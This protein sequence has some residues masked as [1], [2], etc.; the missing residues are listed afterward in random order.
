M[1]QPWLRWPPCWLRRLDHC[2]LASDRHQNYGWPVIRCCFQSDL[3]N[4]GKK[5]PRP[6]QDRCGRSA[7]HSHLRR[8]YLHLAI[9]PGTDLALSPS[10][11][12]ALFLLARRN[13]RF[14]SSSR[15]H[16]WLS[17]FAAVLKEWNATHSVAAHLVC[18]SAGQAAGGWPSS[19]EARGPALSPL[20]D[21]VN[22]SVEGNGYGAGLIN[23]HLLNRSDRPARAGTLLSHRQPMPMGGREGW[24]SGPPAAWPTA[25]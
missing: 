7:S 14:T 2:D 19:G 18:V 15:G 13:H 20:V 4:V 22:Q 8:R 25:M 16:R 23:L 9:Q 5:N 11:G 17:A 10:N 24:R 6:A 21:G 3:V 12:L 1:P